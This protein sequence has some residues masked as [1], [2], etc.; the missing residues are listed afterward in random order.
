VEEIMRL[1]SWLGTFLDFVF[2]RS[3]IERQLDEEFHS[4]IELR[5]AELERQGLSSTEAERQARI[6][7]GGYQKY[8]EECREALGT[9]LLQELVQDVRYGLRQLRRNPGFTIVTVLTLALGIGGT[10]AIFSII[11]GRLLNPWPYKDSGRLVVLVSREP[12]RPK[13]VFWGQFSPAE[14][15]DFQ[16]QNHVFDDL[17]GAVP[18]D[19][20]LTGRDKPAY[21]GCG[22]VTPNTF[23]VLGVAPLI[24]RTLTSEDTKPGAPPVMVLSNEVWKNTFGGDP[25]IVGR[26]LTLNHHPVTVI[27][28]MPPRFKWYGSD[29]WL[30]AV[31]SHS[32]T[33]D[34]MSDSQDPSAIG[35]LKPGVTITQAT[36]D[37]D[38][39]AKRFAAIYPRHHPKGMTLSFESLTD[40]R[41]SS[42]L[43]WMLSLLM[44]GVALLLLIA[45][46]NVANLLLAR[47]TG[48]EKE[49][50]IRVSLGAGRFR[51]VRQL[52]I[53][54][55]LLA[56][57][58]GVLGC[59][60]AWNGLAALKA[61]IPPDHMPGEVVLG[62]NGWVLVFALGTALVS[63]LVFGL[64]PAVLSVKGDSMQ[65]LKASGTR[66]GVSRGHSRLR[67][68]LVVIELTLSLVLLSGAG[69]LFRS[70]WAIQ[71]N[72]LGYAVDNILQVD[73]GLPDNQYKT[74]EQRNQFQLE[75]LRRV[76]ALPGVTSASLT[77][78]LINIA[79][80]NPIEIL[81]Q[82]NFETKNVWYRLVGDN[83]FET[84]SIPLLQ[85]RTISEDDLLQA[86]TVAVVNRAFVKSYFPGRNPLGRQ[87]KVATNWYLGM[88]KN[89]GF[90]IVGVVGDT[91]H[92]GQIELEPESKPQIFLPST[93]AGF[94]WEDPIIRTAGNRAGLVNSIRKEIASLDKDLEVDVTPLR[95]HL[96]GW[97]TEPR[98][99]LELLTGFALLGMILVCIGVYGVLSYAV[100]QRTQEFGVRMALG[101]QVADV[102][103]MVLAWGLR[104]LL[105]GIG[106]GVAAS[107]ALEKV[108]RNRIWGIKS[109]DPL[110]FIVVSL[111]L[112]AVGLVACY[113][114]ARRAAKVDPMVALRY[115]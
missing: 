49:F 112:I 17:L 76:R 24:G 75:A 41:T 66:T 104:W 43:K 57:G 115:E 92:A 84:M 13:V 9:R 28:V 71:H 6:E 22:L 96:Q 82:P 79:V 37:F 109:A 105:V 99:V 81:G 106:I 53:E 4:H 12:T 1:W 20:V 94:R 7:F 26:T 35:H 5:A 39:L 8:M 56:V 72:Q 86:R 103:R 10:T 21:W 38:L 59:L 40:S 51:V 97:Y 100:S 45:S 29:C 19:C 3:H 23:R 67:N 95:G 69:L 62:M 64:A 18:E 48:R 111:I 16:E 52:M 15:L 83:F 90:E 11:Y 113:I 93:V 60:L 87:I 89:S 114:P 68:L 70:F 58:G 42:E 50:A 107:I 2:R 55:L 80:A 74:R 98:F 30:P 88:K 85:G 33:K 63:T 34:E 77:W 47:A 27:G 108:L 73:W 91:M 25:H 46:V 54:S 65:S 44:G 31:F 36:A 102:R 78:P 110:T 101:A 14:F 32:A 61:I